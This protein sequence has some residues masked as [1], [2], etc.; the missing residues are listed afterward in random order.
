MK[1]AV[2]YQK[3]AEN[4]AKIWKVPA[5]RP[6]ILLRQFHLKKSGIRQENHGSGPTLFFNLNHRSWSI[7]GSLSG[8]S[9]SFCLS[10]CQSVSRGIPSEFQI[11]FNKQNLNWIEMI[12]TP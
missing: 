10:V 5:I 3:L 8:R 1:S 7:I 6:D 9:L 11:W 4:P 2:V 12:F